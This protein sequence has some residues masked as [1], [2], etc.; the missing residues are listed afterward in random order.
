MLRF[1][2]LLFIANIGTSMQHQ[3]C[4]IEQINLHYCEAKPD[5]ANQ[6]L[7]TVVMLHGFPESWLTWRHQIQALAADYRVIAPDLLGYNDSDKPIDNTYYQVNK[8]VEL[9]A[10]FIAKVSSNRPVTLVAHDWGG[11]IAW[12]IAAFY[13]DLIKRLVIINAAHPSTFTR[14]MFTNPQQVKKSDYIH[15]MIAPQG[16]DRLAADDY[17]FLRSMLTDAEGASVL[18]DSTLTQ[19]IQAWKKSGALEAMLEYYRQMP[20]LAPRNSDQQSNQFKIPQIRINVPTLV[21]WGELDKAFV[22]QVLDGLEQYVK[23]LQ[24]Q[25]F[26]KASHWLHHEYPKQVNY[27][28]RTF[29]EQN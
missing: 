14:E 12:N 26:P 16:G 19:Y 22:P 27:A 3:Y 9:F 7:H 8:L 29:I 13:P 10:Q 24:V 18:N 5:K 1:L 28:L 17:H 23:R 6:D 11:A 4:Q 2:L 21:L 15:E 25:R 20:Q